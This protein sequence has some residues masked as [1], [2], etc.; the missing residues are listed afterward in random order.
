MPGTH[1][2]INN[3]KYPTEITR[4]IILHFPINFYHDRALKKECLVPLVLRGKGSG[5]RKHWI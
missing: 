3:K 5:K 1:W 2:K 4:N